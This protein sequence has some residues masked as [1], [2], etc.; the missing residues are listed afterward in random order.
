M[1]VIR[2]KSGHNA[3]QSCCKCV[4][5]T[6]HPW[7]CGW[8]SPPDTSPPTA[9]TQTPSKGLGARQH[10]PGKNDK[11][12]CASSLAIAS[13]VCKYL[14]LGL[15]IRSNISHPASSSRYCRYSSFIRLLLCLFQ[16]LYMPGP[17]PFPLLYFHCRYLVCRTL[18]MI[19]A[20]GESSPLLLA[21]RNAPECVQ[22]TL[23]TQQLVLFPKVCG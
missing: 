23:G 7:R 13:C 14:L 5:S 12:S 10:Q 18:P 16:P 20:L 4:S 17:H 6:G 1:F 9:R 3:S 15:G 19:S 11:A 22:P 8:A 21:S 2:C